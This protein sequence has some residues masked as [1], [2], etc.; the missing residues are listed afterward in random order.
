MLW[1]RLSH[2]FNASVVV[3]EWG[4]LPCGVHYL[5]NRIHAFPPGHRDGLKWSK[6]KP[7]WDQEQFMMKKHV[8]RYNLC[9]GLFHCV[10]WIEANRA[11]P[12]WALFVKKCMKFDT[13]IFSVLWGRSSR[14]SFVKT[15]CSS[16]KQVILREYTEPNAWNEFWRLTILSI[17]WHTKLVSRS[18]TLLVVLYCWRHNKL[19]R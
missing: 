13:W 19:R 8:I 12:S 2:I 15:R 18:S 7:N 6:L 5:A 14:Y 16:M 1:L 11:Y 9:R 17:Q 3:W 4:L 10:F